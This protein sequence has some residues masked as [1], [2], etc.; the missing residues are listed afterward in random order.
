MDRD[1]IRTAIA[2]TRRGIADVLDNL[3]GEQL[4]TPSLCDGWDV[5][6]V[7]AHLVSILTEGTFKVALDRNNPRYSPSLSA[8][9][10]GS[11]L[12]RAGWPTP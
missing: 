3:D 7:G 1:R 11:S 10:T 2:D 4:A 6:T 8:T 9:A 5:K 12:F